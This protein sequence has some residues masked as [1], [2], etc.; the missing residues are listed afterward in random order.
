MFYMVARIC[1]HGPCMTQRPPALSPSRQSINIA[2]LFGI[3]MST[4]RARSYA[5]H[6][7]ESTQ[8]S[9][10]T[11]TGLILWASQ[12]AS[13]PKY[14]YYYRGIEPPPEEMSFF[15]HSH[16][17]GNKKIRENTYWYVCLCIA[18]ATGAFQRNFLSL[19]ERAANVVLQASS[20]F[21]TPR[22]F[23][24]FGH[25]RWPSVKCFASICRPA[26]GEWS[27]RYRR[28]HIFINCIFL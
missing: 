26:K 9:A 15:A 20:S 1:S 19:L 7:R 17:V 22:S 16:R 24:V 6:N 23:R 14:P 12:P 11:S 13:H 5:M 27:V 28:G 4:R 10:A 2:Q 8:W 25:V 21:L 3:K 18:A